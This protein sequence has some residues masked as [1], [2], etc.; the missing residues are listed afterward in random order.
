MHIALCAGEPSGDALGADLIQALK[1]I[2]PGATFSGIAGSRMQ[3]EGCESLFPMETLSVMGVAEVIPKLPAILS[4][5]KK[6]IAHFLANPPDVFIGIDAPDFNLGVEKA[7]KKGG[8]K[9]VHYVS[10]TVWAWREKRVL[11]IKKS[12]DLMLCVFP[13]EPAVYEKYKATAKFIGHPAA[14]R[15]ATAS[16]RDSLRAELNLGPDDLLITLMPGS[17]S[18]EIKH[19]AP[20]FLAVA[21]A[22]SVEYPRC[23]FILPLAKPEFRAALE[24]IIQD[25]KFR[26]PLTLTEGHSREAME[27]GDLVLCT[28]GTTT[29]EAMFL[30][31][32]MVVAYRMNAF[33]WWLAQRLVKVKYIAIPNLVA[34]QPLVPEFVQDQATVENLLQAM[35]GWLENPNRAAE[36]KSRYAPY[37]NQLRQDASQQAAEAIRELLT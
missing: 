1:G 36:C 7:L 14:E 18:M 17:R 26:L 10:P 29:L 11:G 34:D 27:A 5:R 4:L 24:Q 20:T 8:I 12:T 30:N 22:L 16:A 31:K 6:L 37:C 28:S 19:L 25:H 23:Q 3:A 2:Y 15:F 32:P 35:R 13:F 21:Q 9:T 33:N